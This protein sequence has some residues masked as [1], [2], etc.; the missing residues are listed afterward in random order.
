MSFCA[1]GST[2]LDSNKPLP[3]SIWERIEAGN[4]IIHVSREK[5]EGFCG[6]ELLCFKLLPAAINVVTVVT[7]DWIELL[8]SHKLTRLKTNRLNL[9]ECTVNGTITTGDKKLLIKKSKVN[10]I[11]TT[12]SR[13]IVI[14]NSTVSELRVHVPSDDCSKKSRKLKLV[15][16]TI[17]KIVFFI[18]NRTVD[19]NSKKSRVNS[20]ETKKIESKE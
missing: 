3:P 15:N 20:I 14:I 11:V 17:E 10:G 5:E 4:K 7:R 12:T 18:G 13:N 6:V 19:M 9:T 16:S 8:G 1:S 2:I